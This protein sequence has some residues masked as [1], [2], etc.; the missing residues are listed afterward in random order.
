MSFF[1]M[2]ETLFIE[3]LK[4]VFELIF[5]FANSFVVHPGY[6]IIFLS[7]AMNLLVLP[8]YRR[9]DAM[10]EE[11]RDTEMRLHDGVS[12]IK[13][14][15]SG[16]ER[17]MILQTYYRQN[18]YKPTNVLHGSVSLLLEIPFFMAAYS[19]LS[20]L[21]ILRGVSFGPI[22]DLGAPDGLIHLFGISINLLPILMTLINLVSSALY[23][24]NF[25]LKTKIQ[26]YGMA[27]FFL[28]F[29][30]SSPSCLVF[31][32]TLNN[33]F[34]LVKTVFYKLKDPKRAVFCLSAAVGVGCIAAAALLLK[35][36]VVRI[37]T[38]A[39]GLL[40]AV[41]LAFMLIRR[42]HPAKKEK[43]PSNAK[44][45]KTCFVMASLLLTVLVGAFIPSVYIAASP[46]EYVD[47][48]YFL[49]PAW[50]TVRTLI[51]AAGLFLVWMRVF[52]WLASE[53]GKVVFERVMCVLC[54]VCVGNYMFFGTNLGTIS[55]TLQY[56]QGMRFEAPEVILNIAVL[57][58]VSIAMY[59]AVKRWRKVVSAA[60]A[61]CVLALG[62]MS[63]VNAVKTESSIEE[64]KSSGVL[65]DDTAPH[66][67][68]S[69]N[70]KNVV[71]IMLDRALGEY[72]PYF[73]AEKPELKRQFAGFTYYCN[74]MSFGGHTNFGVPAL[75]GGYEYTPVELN[76]RDGEKLVN[77]QN[78]A[79]KVMPKLFSDIG[80]DVTVCDPVYANYR[81]IPDVGIFD[82][83]EGVRSYITK[84]KFSDEMQKRATVENTKRNFFCFSVMKSLPLF[85]QPGLYNGGQYGKADAYSP[86]SATYGTQKRS[87]TEKATGLSAPF[88]EA[89]NV[90]QSLPAMTVVSDSEQEGCYVF[91]ANDATHEPTMLELPSYTPSP[92]IDNTAYDA[93]HKD[94][95]TVDG[96]SM[97]METEMQTIHYQSNM[98]C[99]LKLGAWF[100][101]L[102]DRGVWDN[103]R[104][105]LV[106]DH[107]QDLSHFK[108]LDAHIGD[109]LYNVEMYMP[110]LMVKD[111]DATEFTVSDEF[112][113]NADVPT[114]ATAGIIENPVNPYTGK[115]INSSEKNAHDQLVILSHEWSTANNNKNCFLPSAWAKVK[116][117]SDLRDIKSWQFTEG[118]YVFKEHSFGDAK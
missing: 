5:T 98:A 12:H 101:N 111:F 34:S 78:E 105:I 74:T 116:P 93:K 112:M 9:A 22:R 75:L 10:Q 11:S 8:L 49:N 114:L 57:I 64:V 30:Y 79:L 51:M 35:T 25:P 32:W 106:S 38:A 17:M 61:V 6:A 113:T 53:R 24:K 100:D 54:A 110:L 94:R 2:L 91:L 21:E 16:D 97:Q 76:R 62:G 42:K 65:E 109:T 81:W 60:L 85:V 88:M 86:T 4:L 15:F 56:E 102:R 83:M 107:G 48:S 82:G 90:L 96:V 46:Q 29:L 103:T 118:S 73:M 89:Y 3:P 55:A 115:T 7:L 14:T 47:L 31:Y 108:D 95:F 99:F 28:V 13:K 69:K 40:L 72:V 37:C 66:F 68:L 1:S 19:F 45:N 104:I 70:G 52:Y 77:K 92:R 59:F 84:G 67:N 117:G 50:Y 44:P 63:V 58:A 23:L 20:H 36:P 80:C 71:V 41:P 33:L 26:L 39:V 27:L 18:N 87:G 43:K